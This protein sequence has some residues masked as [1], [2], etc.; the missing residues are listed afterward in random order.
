VNLLSRAGRPMSGLALTVE[1][2]VIG[3]RVFSTQVFRSI[4]QLCDRKKI[5]RVELMNSY[6]AGE[7]REVAN[8]VCRACGSL[9]QI[10][11]PSAFDELEVLALQQG[12]RVRR[13]IVEFTGL[14]EECQ[15][16]AD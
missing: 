10:P 3:H 2:G 14:C 8:L 12:M 16:H 15:C 13:S 11:V 1:L 5:H 7:P 6:M 4:S 9:A